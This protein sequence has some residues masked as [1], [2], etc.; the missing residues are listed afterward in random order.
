METLKGKKTLR[1][2][3]L[4]TAFLGAFAIALILLN[5]GLNYPAP[6]D[7]QI[8]NEYESARVVTVLSDTLAPDPDVAQVEIGLQELELEVLTG[9]YK[10]TRVL[11]KNPVTRLMNYPAAVGTKMVISS[12]DGFVSGMVMGYD[13]TGGLYLL[14]A[15]FCAAVVFFGR[16]KG[17]RS[18]FALVFTLVCVIFLFIPLLLKGMNPILAALICVVLSTVVTLTA[19]SGFTPKTFVAGLSCILCTLT[20]GGIARAFGSLMHVSTYTTPEAENLMFIAQ[21]SALRLP[22]ILFAGILIAASGAMMDTTISVASALT[23]IKEVD[24]GITPARLLK[25][26]LNIGRDI[27]GTMTNTLI[28]AFAGSGINALLVI[29]LYQ[30][31]YLRTVNLDLLAVEILQGLSASTALALSVP[32]TA[33]LGA[34]VIGGAGR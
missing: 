5:A 1:N 4:W 29:F 28:L 22:D 20:A 23:E 17:V 9:A 15:L 11:L 18:L 8:G 31:P 25:S 19:L 24:P 13:R 12:Y 3:V 10:G 6:P 16:S 33:L 26:G 2:A 7:V 21:N 30:M 27:M 14:A 34:K 32:V